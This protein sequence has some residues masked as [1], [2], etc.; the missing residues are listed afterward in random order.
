MTGELTQAA[1]D[2]LAERQRQVE[3]EGWSVEHDDAHERGELAS[4]AA[5]YAKNSVTGPARWAGLPPP[6]WPWDCRWW[7]P[8]TPRRDL[9]KAAALII[10]EIERLDR[11]AEPHC[12]KD[13]AMTDKI[14][15]LLARWRSQARFADVDEAHALRDRA[16]ELEATLRAAVLP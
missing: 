11:I 15:A 3:T 13:G 10:A 12:G 2:V 1:R 8:T 5:C 6:D 7:K 4:A 14:C 16:D 9:V